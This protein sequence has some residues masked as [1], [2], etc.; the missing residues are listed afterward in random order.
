MVANDLT[1]IGGRNPRLSVGRVR[2][3]LPVARGEIGIRHRRR[4]PPGR[5]NSASKKVWP[6][7]VAIEVRS[8]VA[9]MPVTRMSLRPRLEQLWRR[10]NKAKGPPIPQAHHL[11]ISLAAGGNM[12]QACWE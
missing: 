1:L 10:I 5:P 11:S 3:L 7:A 9:A 8:V 4:R 6:E 2:Q 12:A